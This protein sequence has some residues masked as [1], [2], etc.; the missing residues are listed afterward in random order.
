MNGKNCTRFLLHAHSMHHFHNTLATVDNL[1]F[2]VKVMP[3]LNEAQ[4]NNA[5]S[6][7]EAWESQS[8]IARQLNVSQSTIARLWHRYQQHGSSRDR[9]RSGRPCVTTPAQ[10]RFIRLRHLR[11]RFTTASSTASVVPGLRTISDQTVRN[12][13]REAGIRS[14]FVLFARTCLYTSTSATT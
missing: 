1:K 5:I 2:G 6:H 7:L 3:G 8:A 13:L 11:N 14:R 9:P 12:R 10:D 4:R